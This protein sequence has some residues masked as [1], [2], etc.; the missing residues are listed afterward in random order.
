MVTNPLDYI[1]K[2]K[3]SGVTYVTTHLRA[4]HGKVDEF[5]KQVHQ[6]HMK[7][8]LVLGLD[9]SIEELKPYLE[10]IDLVLV[11]AIKPGFYG[12]TF[13]EIVYERV[14]QLVN[15]RE[16]HSLSYLI[17]IDGGV[18]YP[19]SKKLKQM[20]VDLLVMGVFT[21]FRQTKSLDEACKKYIKFMEGE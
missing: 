19:I 3:E 5:I 10:D 11:M 7:V 15:Y 17:S 21:I 18:D 9:E 12:Q 20:K 14:E 16:Y 8:G 6:Q 13:H 2:C 1:H 4:L